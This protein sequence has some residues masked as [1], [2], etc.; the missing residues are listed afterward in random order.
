MVTL[1]DIVEEIIGE[2]HDEFDKL[3]SF[4]RRSGEGWVAGGFASLSHV[5]DAGQILPTRSNERTQRDRLRS[6]SGA[7]RR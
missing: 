6:P 5:R 7:G 1:E 3:P 4:L 2:I